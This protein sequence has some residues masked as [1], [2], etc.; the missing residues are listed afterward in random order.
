[1][2]KHVLKFLVAA[3]AVQALPAMAAITYIED[4]EA[5][6]PA[7]ESGWLGVNSNLQNYYGVGQGRGNNPDGLWI[8][9]GDA[10]TSG[11]TLVEIVFDPT[12]GATLTSFDVDVAGY[13]PVN[14]TIY[15]MSG[16]TL[17]STSVTLTN[18]AYSD[19]GVYAHYGVTS[20][21]GVSKF[22][23]SS[24]SGQ[25]EGWTS[26]DNVVVVADGASQIPAPAAILLGT[27][28]TGL[29]GWLRR[30]RTL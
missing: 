22:S 29:V 12:F 30:R 21:N 9:D 1:M 25:I 14:L 19:P 5:A 24:G 17:L 10:A 2:Q 23:F 16:N 6:F 28:G 26:I 3:V 27:I 8:S 11:D 4:F 18:G 13:A 20:G 7:W 15:D